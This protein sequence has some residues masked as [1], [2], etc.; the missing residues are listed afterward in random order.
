IAS[1]RP[2][3]GMALL[4][5]MFVIILLA[6]FGALM[7]GT[8]DLHSKSNR[9]VADA[10]QVQEAAEAGLAH[11]IGLFHVQLTEDPFNEIIRGK[12]A[13]WNGGTGDDGI[14]QG[15][16][17]FEIPDADAIPSTGLVLNG[18][19]YTVRVSDDPADDADPSTDS[20]QRLMVSCTAVSASGAG[21]SAEVRAIVERSST[22]Y[23]VMLDGPMTFTRP[24]KMAASCARGYL[25]GVIDPTTVAS[26]SGGGWFAPSGITIPASFT[27]G[28]SVASVATIPSIAPSTR[29]SSYMTAVGT[30]SLSGTGVR[31]YSGDVTVTS[32]VSSGVNVTVVA[33]GSITVTAGR[34]NSASSAPGNNIS[35]IAG[36]D[37]L[38][39]GDAE[40]RGA[41]YCGGQISMQGTSRGNGGAIYCRGDQ[42]GSVVGGTPQ[43]H[44]FNSSFSNN[45]IGGCGASS[46]A[47][48]GSWRATSWYPVIGS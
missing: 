26:E 29:C 23:R 40:F 2:R 19:R 46:G 25:N 13:V 35:L 20:N 32:T 30:V 41:V 9:N 33:T 22:D 16:T 6:T 38:L 44:V 21:P 17:P 42:I 45:M 31:C 18:Y 39:N 7:V 11:A 36:E 1:S 14:L 28:R 15:V 5:T 4:V 43:K 37:V 10:I 47:L 34:I 8:V 27:G 24:M 3:R 12:N 48:V